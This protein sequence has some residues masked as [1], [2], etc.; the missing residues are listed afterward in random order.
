M[1]ITSL[2]PKIGYEKASEIAQFA[3]KQ[4]LSLRQAALKTG[5][6]NEKDFDRIVDPSKMTSS[7]S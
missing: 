6:I 1:L 4:N 2:A 5:Y 3:F 7:K